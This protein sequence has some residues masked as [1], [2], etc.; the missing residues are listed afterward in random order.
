MSS[1][2]ADNDQSSVIL[3]N[4]NRFFRC[5]FF[6]YALLAFSLCWPFSVWCWKK[7]DKLINYQKTFIKLN[8]FVQTT[9]VSLKLKRWPNWS[10]QDV[11]TRFLD[12]CK[13]NCPNTGQPCFWTN[14][15]HWQS[16]LL[17]KSLE[18][19]FRESWHRLNCSYTFSLIWPQGPCYTLG[20]WG[21]CP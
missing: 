18:Q 16:H 20:D 6:Q 2:R 3:I 19:M 4:Y 1:T 5:C 10:E 8:W 7:I 9:C 14:C 11:I 15:Y 12:A 21:Q 17:K 13:E